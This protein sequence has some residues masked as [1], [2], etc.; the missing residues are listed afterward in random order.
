MHADRWEAAGMSAQGEPVR[1]SCRAWLVT[2]RCNAP[3]E[4]ILWGKLIPADDLGPRCYDCAARAVGH[5]ALTDPAWAI[6][7]LRDLVRVERSVLDA[8]KGVS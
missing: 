8:P 4:F 6:F 1:E 3:A 2:D 7:H 5:R